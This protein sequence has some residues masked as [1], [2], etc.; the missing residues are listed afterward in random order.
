MVLILSAHH[1]HFKVIMVI[2]KVLMVSAIVLMVSTYLRVRILKG[3]KGK[4][5]RPAK[6]GTLR[7]VRSPRLPLMTLTGLE[8]RMDKWIEQVALVN[9][10]YM[11]LQGEVDRLSAEVK[12]LKADSEAL[13]RATET[14]TKTGRGLFDAVKSV[15]ERVDSISKYVLPGAWGLGDK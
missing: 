10:A 7:M 2:M 1:E 13:F 15:A 14:Q 5:E 11:Q 8:I 4:R 12:S 9:G 6:V 3:R